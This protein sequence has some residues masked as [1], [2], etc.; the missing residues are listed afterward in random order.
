MAMAGADTPAGLDENQSWD[1]VAR[2][3]FPGDGNPREKLART[4]LSGLSCN[5]TTNQQMAVVRMAKALMGSNWVNIY[6][7]G[8]PT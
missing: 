7:R 6:T 2:E 3:T 5:A 4:L 8:S 1:Y